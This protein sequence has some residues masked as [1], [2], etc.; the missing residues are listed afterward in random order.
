MTLLTMRAALHKVRKALLKVTFSMKTGELRGPYRLVKSKTEHFLTDLDGADDIK[1]EQM[2][3]QK[4]ELTCGATHF[5]TVRGLAERKTDMNA[6]TALQPD[7]RSRLHS[8]ASDDSVLS[9]SAL[10][11]FKEAGLNGDEINFLVFANRNPTP[12][13][14]R[15]D[16]E[17]GARFRL[18]AGVMAHCLDVFGSAGKAVYWLHQPL[19]RFQRQSPL[20][21]I[22]NTSN[23]EQLHEYLIQ[24]EEGNFA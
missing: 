1:S 7:L 12:N 20:Q 22:E 21:F 19:S 13:A 4:E 23:V 2:Q 5:D 6:A 14:G 10:N 16:P 18:M 24:V 8:L 17:D 15:L 9:V 11:I 3:K